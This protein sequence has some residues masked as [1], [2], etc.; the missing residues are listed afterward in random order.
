MHIPVCFRTETEV[1]APDGGAPR[2]PAPLA[3]LYIRKWVKQAVRRSWNVVSNV[4]FEEFVAC[5]NDCTRQYVVVNAMDVY[6]VTP[7]VVTLNGALGLDAL[8]CPTAATRDDVSV[9]ISVQANIS[10]KLVE[11]MAVHEFGHV[12][13]FQHEHIR[14][15]R[16]ADCRDAGTSPLDLLTTYDQNSIMNYC[17]SEGNKSGVLTDL[18]IQGVQAFYGPNPASDDDGDGVPDQRDNCPYAPNLDQTNSNLAAEV[19]VSRRNG[20]PADDGHVPQGGD[21]PNYVQRWQQTYRGDACDP[22]PVMRATVSATKATAGGDTCTTTSSTWSTNAS[23]RFEGVVG[24]PLGNRIPR[25]AT[26][27]QSAICRCDAVGQQYNDTLACAL[28]PF[29]NCVIGNDSAFP[30]GAAQGVYKRLTPCGAQGTLLSASTSF[31]QAPVGAWGYAPVLTAAKVW[32]SRYDEAAFGLAPGSLKAIAWSH[33]T[34]KSNIALPPPDPFPVDLANNYVPVS[35]SRVNLPFVPAVLC[36]GCTF[37]PP[38]DLLS[39]RDGIRLPPILL[40]G[41]DATEGRVPLHQFSGVLERAALSYE[42]SALAA[43]GTP[44]SEV[45]VSSDNGLG[46][47]PGRNDT[48][49]VLVNA[50]TGFVLGV[51]SAGPDK[52]VS[53][54]AATGFAD[55]NLPVP[56]RAYVATLGEHGTVMTLRAGNLIQMDVNQALKGEP[57]AVVQP[58][59]GVVP[60]APKAMAWDKFTQTLFV[61]D[62]VSPTSTTRK[63]RLLQIDALGRAEQRWIGVSTSSS[64][65]PTRFYVQTTSDGEVLISLSFAAR[66]EWAVLNAAGVV[67]VAGQTNAPLVAAP[68]LNDVTLALPVAIA[69]GSAAEKGPIAIRQVS[70]SRMALGACTTTWLKNQA[71]SEACGAAWNGTTAAELG[72]YTCQNP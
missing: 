42:P 66:T 26:N 50:G 72:S 54:D 55:E 70:R 30:N 29:S 23:F 8:R 34:P 27:V 37:F 67:Q 48:T 31:L 19:G 15:D 59:T 7:S 32:D 68:L 46:A 36:A 41:T 20:F 12:L 25:T 16:V 58:I 35:A 64:A 53:Y 18:D 45:V 47:I 43:L 57:E 69:A 65:F 52:R 17:N 22:V 33:A 6:A 28:D 62:Q 4:R 24:D 1:E 71:P 9:N 21:P 44:N 38:W 10:R 2:P 63:L 49:G 13:G 3:P 60:S 14:T 56:A 11:H 40:F 5:P 61:L 51:F 39:W